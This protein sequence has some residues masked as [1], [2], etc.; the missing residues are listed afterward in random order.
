MAAGDLSTVQVG[1][2]TTSYTLIAD[3]ATYTG[4]AIT[5]DVTGLSIRLAY[6]AAAPAVGS[7][8]FIL[9]TR[10]MVWPVSALQAGFKIYGL[11]HEAA[12]KARASRISRA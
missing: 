3:G 9:L 2:I 6:A 10:G 7:D 12:T 8:D 4:G 1:L 11:A 5:C